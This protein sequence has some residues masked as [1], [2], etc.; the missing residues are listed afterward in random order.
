MSE[1]VESMIRRWCRS[2]GGEPQPPAR[3]TD[4]CLTFDR[5]ASIARSAELPDGAARQHLAECPRCR[6]LLADFREA[7]AEGAPGASRQPPASAARLRESPDVL[8]RPVRYALGAAAAAVLLLGVGS[9]I[10]LSTSPPGPILL[11]ADVGLRDHILAGTTPKSG[12]TFATGDAIM[13][14]VDFARAGRLTLINI[15]PNGT[16]DVMDAA[17]SVSAKTVATGLGPGS[18]TVGPYRLVGRGGEETFLLIVFE[19]HVPADR[20]RLIK[21]LD[22]A[23]EKDRDVEKLVRM[24]RSWPAEVKVIRIDHVARKQ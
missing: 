16:M 1:N 23:C 10:Y 4:R 9:A 18:H 19:G 21:Q 8:S 14:R 5:A 3:P 12:R 17:P 24:I 6:E 20:A 7:L 15:D 22:E 11:A 13:F 2:E